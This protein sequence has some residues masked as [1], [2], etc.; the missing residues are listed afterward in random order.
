MQSHLKF[1]NK[2]LLKY[3]KTVFTNHDIRNSLDIKDHFLVMSFYQ[4]KIR[5]KKS[6][7]GFRVSK[8]LEKYWYA[9]FNSF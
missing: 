2:V 3:T 8:V 5:L 4:S 9:I 1:K 7:L 6:I